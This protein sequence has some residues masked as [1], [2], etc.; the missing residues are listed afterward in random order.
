MGITKTKL[1][2]ICICLLLI[3]IGTSRLQAQ[4][5]DSL[6][7]ILDTKYPQEKIHVHFDK[8]Y[9]NAGE[10]IWFKAYLSADNL[11][12]P[13][14]K[15]L[16]AELMDDKGNV[17]QRKMMPI[18]QAGAAASF[19]LPDT[20]KA[21]RLFLRAYTSWM[22]NFDSTLLYIKS[23]QIIPAK[24]TAKKTAPAITYSVQFFPEGG[25]LVDDITSRVA[26]KA[27][28]SKGIPFLIKGDIVDGKGKKMSAFSSLHDGMGY[29]NLRPSAGEKYKAIW[30]DKKGVQHETTLPEAKKQGMVLSVQTGNS[31]LK[32][33]LTRPDSVDAVL[34]S[35]TVVAQI[36]QRLVYSAKIN[37][38]K[39][40]SVTAPI[41]IDS[42]PT[43]VMQLTVFNAVQE[44]VA[45]RV[46]FIN[47]D[48]Y[49]F[50]TDLHSGEKNLGK[51]GRN[52]IQIDVGDVL[53]SNL[54][55]SVT[56]A[57]LNPITKNEESIYSQLLLS[58][59]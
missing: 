44:P 56:D 35:Y 43:G 42:L 38:T 9:Y 53:M 58:S 41:E 10:T 33:T 14:S 59:D 45:E 50:I 30:K 57:S 15:S 26:F 39:K 12:G 31:Q 11:S 5:I 48:N 7:N 29:C 21:T 19:D 2:R 1:C 54:S 13:I 18:L 4:Y 22:L 3:S 46:V 47:H 32:Y 40:A 16:Y 27:N 51:R 24:S 36:Q 25:D 34:T 8:A 37:M 28:D 23:L 55:V 17:V 49:S 52:T 6:L 20:I